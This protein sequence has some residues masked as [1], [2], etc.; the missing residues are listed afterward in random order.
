M[1]GKPGVLT[2]TMV[3]ENGGKSPVCANAV[4]EN[5]RKIKATL[6]FMCKTKWENQALRMLV[7]D[8]I[9]TKRTCI[10]RV[11]KSYN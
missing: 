9:R 3:M 8:K 4:A 7:I 1:A 11:E 10:S 2:G 5:N 6:F